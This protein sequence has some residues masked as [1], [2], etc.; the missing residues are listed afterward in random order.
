MKHMAFFIADGTGITAEALGHSLLSRFGGLHVDRVTLPCP[1]YC[2][3][4][5]KNSLVC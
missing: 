3:P 2:D 1:G 5:G 4:T